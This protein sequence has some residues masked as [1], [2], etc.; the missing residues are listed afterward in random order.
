LSVDRVAFNRLEA[1]A[2]RFLVSEAILDGI[3]P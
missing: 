2:G 3:E 1:M